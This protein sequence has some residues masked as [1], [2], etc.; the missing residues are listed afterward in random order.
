MASF[1]EVNSF[2]G[3]FMHLWQSGRDADLHL[4]TRAGQACVVLRLGLGVHPHQHQVKKVSPSRQRRRDRR[5][6]ARQESS[7]NVD[8]AKDVS[9]KETNKD[10]SGKEA[11]LVEGVESKDDAA[12]DASGKEA[13]P[14]DNVQT[15]VG[16]I[17][18]VL[19]AKFIVVDEICDDD[20]FGTSASQAAKND[21]AEE[22][23]DLSDLREVGGKHEIV[24]PNSGE[25]LIEV[26]PQNCKFSDRDL[27][28]KL[29][30]AGFKLLCLPW[31][32]NTGRHFYT[33]GFKTTE[34]SYI[35][36]SGGNRTLPRGFYRVNSSWKVN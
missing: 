34:E 27:A 7:A 9:A 17:S 8:I 25:V 11:E 23:L 4:E 29:T 22:N 33:A 35:S 6:A 2:L 26:R 20:A 16:E 13:E 36:K 19:E 3:K 18:T 21:N 12:K 5:A 15:K 32:A 14:V 1:A 10:V 24:E 31:V 28:M 30:K